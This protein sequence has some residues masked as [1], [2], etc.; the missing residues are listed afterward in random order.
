LVALPDVECGPDCVV[1]V[2][3]GLL[4]RD[5]VVVA[6]VERGTA[7]VVVVTALTDVLVELATVDRELDVEPALALC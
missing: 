7:V 5:V 2:V 6:P 4:G 3:E 1:V